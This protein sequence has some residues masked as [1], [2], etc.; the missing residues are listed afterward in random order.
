MSAQSQ[1]SAAPRL[2]LAAA[3]P[4]PLAP[5]STTP[6][7]SKKKEA[8]ALA[9]D[10]H[11][12]AVVRQGTL[13]KRRKRVPGWQ[14][15]FYVCTANHLR[16][17]KDEKEAGEEQTCQ[18]VIDLCAATVR[19]DPKLQINSTFFMDFAPGAG[20]GAASPNGMQTM[21][22]R[23]PDKQS[24]EAWVSCL[25]ALRPP[26]LS[27]RDA[28]A[29]P[30]Q[31]TATPAP[32]P[33][34]TLQPNV[35][36]PSLSP[37]AEDP[38]RDAVA[39]PVQETA[40]PAPTPAPTLQPMAGA[41]P[42][43]GGALLTPPRPAQA[44]A[45]TLR[46]SPPVEMLCDEVRG[47]ITARSSPGASAYVQRPGS[48][49]ERPGSRGEPPVRT[50]LPAR[51]APSPRLRQMSSPP[52]LAGDENVTEGEDAPV[53]L[54]IFV[55]GDAP[56][57]TTVARPDVLTYAGVAALMAEHGQPVGAGA[58][59][60]ELSLGGKWEVIGQLHTLRERRPSL[61]PMVAAGSIIGGGGGGDAEHG[62][63]GWELY[64][65]F[66][67]KPA[68][69]WQAM[70][71]FCAA[72]AP[73]AVVQVEPALQHWAGREQ[74][75]LACFNVQYASDKWQTPLPLKA[76]ETTEGKTK[77][78][79]K[80][81]KKK[82]KVNVGSAGRQ[83]A[84]PRAGSA[85]SSP[86][87]PRKSAQEAFG[88][89]MQ[90]EHKR[91]LAQ[92][93]KLQEDEAARIR[94]LSV[95]TISPYALDASSDWGDFTRPPSP[96]ADILP[97]R[98][99][100]ARDSPT[101]S[102]D[103]SGA[104][105]T[106]VQAEGTGYTLR[107]RAAEVV[108]MKQEKE[109][110][111]EEDKKKECTFRPRLYKTSFVGASST[112]VD[113]LA[114]IELWHAKTQA[115]IE[116]LA[117]KQEED[118]VEGVGKA[119][120]ANAASSKMAGRNVGRLLAQTAVSKIRHDHA[121][122]TVLQLAERD[123][124]RIENQPRPSAPRVG[125][126]TWHPDAHYA[127]KEREHTEHAKVALL[128]AA[129]AMHGK[130]LHAILG[131]EAAISLREL[132]SR[133]EASFPGVLT[134]EEQSLLLSA[135]NAGVDGVVRI[136]EFVDFVHG[137][138][139]V[140]GAASEGGGYQ[141]SSTYADGG[142]VLGEEDRSAGGMFGRHA[143]AGSDE[144]E[145]LKRKLL[146][147][148][149][150]AHGVDLGSLFES[151]DVDHDG[152]L[153][154]LELGPHLQKMLPGVLSEQQE[155][156]LLAAIDTDGDG[157]V[158]LA[159]F[160]TFVASRHGARAP[161]SRPQ[162]RSWVGARASAKH[163]ELE[164]LKRKL[165]AASY[166]QHGVDLGELFESYDVDHDGALELS[167]IG[168]HLQ[169]MLPGVLSRTHLDK[170]LGAM[171]TDHD[172]SISLAEF[173]AFVESRDGARQM[174]IVD[175]GREEREEERKRTQ[176]AAR[177]AE[178]QV[179][180]RKLLAASYTAHGVDLGELFESYDVD[181]D[182]A[183]QLAE[184]GPH[185]QKML[186]GVLSKSHMDQLLAA[187]DVDG[188]GRVSL[189]EF[190][191]FVKTQRHPQGHTYSYE[192]LSLPPASI[193]GAV[194]SG[195]DRAQSVEMAPA[196]QLLVPDGCSLAE[197]EQSSSEDEGESPAAADTRTESWEAVKSEGIHHLQRKGANSPD[198]GGH[199]PAVDDSSTF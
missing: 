79:K 36:S 193:R 54:H 66:F 76:V 19:A 18:G 154:L 177:H 2:A 91:K 29:A 1:E 102:I 46:G 181:H 5:P 7:R 179:L 151:Y 173:C 196:A 39:A 198:A 138:A 187:M 101:W 59:L 155:K 183:L 170:L 176:I 150:T 60:C 129:D 96:G 146:A 144:L 28:V 31:E 23:A 33:A 169:K 191:T 185:L 161:S 48:R 141:P 148:S 134:V 45:P 195:R 147:A 137:R 80:V 192:V 133:L 165:L 53:P 106:S 194:F 63:A 11:Q 119:F 100:S 199:K 32:T 140:G 156:K 58:V 109:V 6:V 189:A 44:P 171:D 38:R 16:Y 17:Y 164:S 13:R 125:A 52:L 30:V 84:S 9:R 152:A 94:A 159:E 124:L 122:E 49:G 40:T 78:V 132:T 143:H 172:G 113:V 67:E 111:A 112:D 168:S 50:T 43:P 145:S 77:K 135:A 74:E 118:I 21:T 123:A 115:K 105:D 70:V 89:R 97:H 34:P 27:P 14:T 26:S 15:G 110:R 22:L 158:T 93:E 188:D 65:R 95:P 4:P 175:F 197:Q 35:C 85:R 108:L 8:Q 62:Q 139:P 72:H 47:L 24:A 182:G 73:Q 69:A 90:L 116:R 186:P 68:N 127:R 130:D 57:D 126:L 87:S 20:D 190:C 42:R 25:R 51:F 81:K 56:I 3:A 149:Y 82:K 103:S 153:E 128:Q 104:S 184:L 117:K 174:E 64:V 86:G 99:G 121:R 163:E 55:G 10:L 107:G 12:E 136:H 75:L 131:A 88:A 178:L 166:T 180:K 120:V 92:R 160:A 142:G 61:H 114:R 71:Q 37:T 98:I 157:Q 41:P 167:E 83:G 162:R